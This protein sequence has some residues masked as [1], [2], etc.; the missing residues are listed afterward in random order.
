[1][2]Q[3]VISSPFITLDG[4][5]GVGK[6]TQIDRL[7]DYLRDRGL[8]SLLVR[9]PGTTEIGAKLRELLLDSDLDLHRRTEAMLFM[10]SRCEMIEKSIRPA[11]A[12]GTCVVS[13]RFLL[14]NVVYQS[15]GGDVTSERLWQMGRLANDGLVPG[16]TLL[17]DMP[18]V[19][20]MKRLGGE[21]DR[22]ERRGVT[23]MESVRQAF[24]AELP[25][26]SP[27]TAIVNA[28]QSADAVTTEMFQHV[29]AYLQ[30]LG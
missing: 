15:V 6:S 11:L 17:L 13:D 3:S 20:A 18:A 9:D 22:M 5:D 1:M 28:D 29:D 27:N 12:N 25:H 24:L 21:T 14:A 10:A 26:S 2:T 30:Q 16:L 4:I 8:P 19:A 7:V 23:Y